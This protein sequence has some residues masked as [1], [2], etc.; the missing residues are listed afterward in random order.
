MRLNSAERLLA[1][2]VADSGAT[3]GVGGIPET[4][5]EHCLLLPRAV[6]D[7]HVLLVSDI[8][9]AVAQCTCVRAASR[10]QFEQDSFVRSREIRV[11]CILQHGKGSS[12]SSFGNVGLWLPGI[13]AKLMLDRLSA[14]FDR[15]RF[16]CRP[17]S[18]GPISTNIGKHPRSIHGPGKFSSA[19]H[20][21]PKIGRTRTRFGRDQAKFDRF[22]ATV[23]RIWPVSGLICTNLNQC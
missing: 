23:G 3:S 8:M 17:N 10:R 13:R 22:R 5:A 19:S 18:S 7:P 1:L 15:F 16:R 21:W 2:M 9:S 11:E 6:H 12:L 4:L 14:N 20:W